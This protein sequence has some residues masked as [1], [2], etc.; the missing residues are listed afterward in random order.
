M[1]LPIVLL[2][3]AGLAGAG[4]LMATQKRLPEG[5]NPFDDFP[6]GVDR[7]KPIAVEQVK[8]SSGNRYKVTSFRHSDGRLYYVAEKVG[9]VDWIS[10]FF[11]PGTGVRQR[12]HANADN[13]SDLAGMAADFDMAG[14]VAA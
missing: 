4:Y 5:Q 14:Q 13:T 6:P 1:A 12:W 11:T 7:T 3:G 10:Y 9:D 2:I 8:A